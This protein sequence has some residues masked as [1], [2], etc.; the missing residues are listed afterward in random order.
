MDETL[1]EQDEKEFVISPELKGVVNCW[2]W[3]I[4][5]NFLCDFSLSLVLFLN[6]KIIKFEKKSM[7]FM[8]QDGDEEEEIVEGD[9]WNKKV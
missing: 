7:R 9:N 8:A 1:E 4:Y 2:L 5:N 6:I 3:N